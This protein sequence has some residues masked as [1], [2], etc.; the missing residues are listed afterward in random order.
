MLPRRQKW[1]NLLIQHPEVCFLHKRSCPRTA[2]LPPKTRRKNQNPRKRSP[3]VYLAPDL[4]DKHRRPQLSQKRKNQVFLE[5]R[6]HSHRFSVSL[7]LL[8]NPQ[9]AYS[10]M[11]LLQQAYL[12]TQHRHLVF[13]VANQN[14]QKT[15][16]SRLLLPNPQT[17]HFLAVNHRRKR[18]CSA[19]NKPLLSV[20]LKVS[21]QGNFSAA[22]SQD[23]CL[24]MRRQGLLCSVFP[25]QAQAICSSHLECSL[26]QSLNP[27][28]TTAKKVMVLLHRTRTRLLSTLRQK[29]SNLLKVWKFRNHPTPRSST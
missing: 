12:G 17:A 10:Q 3:R 1:P 7:P 27:M 6:H 26:Q 21:P 19:H 18:V 20:R 8:T 24:V 23:H 11:P 5:Q 29:R 25:R 15:K 14:H 2:C 4:V 9:E 22:H 28:E 13:S 16:K